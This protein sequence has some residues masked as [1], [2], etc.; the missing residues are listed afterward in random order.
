MTRTALRVLRTELLRGVAPVAGA[1]F[2]VAGVAVLLNETEQWV[3]RWNP[4]AESLRVT[5]IV[6]VPLAVAAGAWQAGRERRRRIGEQL[7]STARPSWQPV[8]VSWA[9]VTLGTLAGLAAAWLAGAVLVAPIA[10]YGGRGWG[11]MLAGAFAGLAVATS[12]GVVLGRFVPSRFVAP[13]A[14]VLA[15]VAGG[16]LTYSNGHGWSWLWPAFDWTRSGT[17]YLPT[18]FQLWQ[19][20][21]FGALAVAL[22]VLAAARRRWL[23]AF[24]AAIAVAV[25]VPIATGPGWERWQPDPA[26]REP[27][28][29]GDVCL[30]RVNAFLLDEITPLAREQLARWD[31]VPG[32]FTRAVDG[33]VLGDDAFPPPE[34]TAVVYLNGLVTWRGGLADVS[35]WDVPVERTLAQSVDDVVYASCPPRELPEDVWRAIDVAR[36]WALGESRL[37]ADLP[38]TE[39]RQWMG[40]YLTAARACDEAGFTSLMEELR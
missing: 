37:L 6:L 4:L 18:A 24:P 15:Y 25:A 38:V 1:A 22:V 27:V 35:V 11:W 30:S 5:L 9:A 21:W 40:R 12:L 16:V 39:Q 10:T 3:G 7:E 2:A 26:A 28:C 8:V 19:L 13:V 23:A 14:G 33:A 31:G 29:A 32:G 34:G 17:D 36:A 20:L